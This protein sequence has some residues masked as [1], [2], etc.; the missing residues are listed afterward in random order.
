MRRIFQLLTA[1]A[2][3]CGISAHAHATTIVIGTATYGS[4]NYNLVYDD[5]LGITWLDYTN[6]SNDWWNQVSWAAGLNAPGVL[7]YNFNP[8]V[9][10]SWAGDWRLPSTLNQ[11][12]GP[13]GVINCTSGEMWHL[14]YTE[15][16]NTG[17]PAFNSG[18]FQNLL[19]DAYWSGTS[20][21]SYQFRAWYFNFSSGFQYPIYKSSPSG[22]CCIYAL[23]VRPGTVSAVP[24]PGTMLLLGSGVVGIGVFRKR[25]GRLDRR[26]L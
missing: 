19:P 9:Y 2:L 24:E 26:T 11:S 22:H 12:G 8:G 5:D 20:F 1:M 14:Y 16:G 3:V 13:C 21:P 6:P 10:I 18:V 7:T 17:G 25:F 15:L 23:A 4:A